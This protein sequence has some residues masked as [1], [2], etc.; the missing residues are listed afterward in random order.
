MAV[1]PEQGLGPE[2]PAGTTGLAAAYASV[3]GL[4]HGLRRDGAGR[5]E[6]D[7]EG[8][9]GGDGARG[10]G[11]MGVV[12]D[13]GI[14][15]IDVEGAS[16]H[17]AMLEGKRTF[18]N[19]ASG[20]PIVSDE[21]LAQ[22]VG[23]ALAVRC[24]DTLAV[25]PTELTTSFITILA[26]IH[27][28]KFFHFRIS[29]DF[30]RSYEDC[31]ANS[32]SNLAGFF[33]FYS[34]AVDGYS[35]CRHL[36][37]AIAAVHAWSMANVRPTT[38]EVQ[39]SRIVLANLWRGPCSEPDGDN[40]S[41]FPFQV[42]QAGARH[43]SLLAPAQQTPQHKRPADLHT[44][45]FRPSATLLEP[46]QTWVRGL[47]STEEWR[48]GASSPHHTSRSRKPSTEPAK[49]PKKRSTSHGLPSLRCTASQPIPVHQ[50]SIVK[51]RRE[52][53]GHPQSVERHAAQPHPARGPHGPTP[54]PHGA[55]A[56]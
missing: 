21:V 7:L 46:F 37:P 28:V 15:F 5:A 26:A 20:M 33:A 4:C 55:A 45:A 51:S 8:G 18:K 48:I 47:S 44:T 54:D 49:S 14:Q 3:A 22:M 17:V 38:V 50:I 52:Y 11:R 29:A 30:V 34:V 41:Q 42:W 25:S 16:W 12:D 1:D 36:A 35:R 24:S 53:H 39:R 32:S 10:E 13:G 23:E 19:I 2:T 6:D 9:E 27:C 56:A 43:P 31:F 40:S